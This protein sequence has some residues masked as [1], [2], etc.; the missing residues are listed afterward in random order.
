MDQAGKTMTFGPG[1]YLAAGSGLF[2]L[3][4]GCSLHVIHILTC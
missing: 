4:A 3:I 2:T 1:T